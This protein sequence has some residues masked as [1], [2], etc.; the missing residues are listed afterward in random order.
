MHY[1][2]LIQ[3][4]RNQDEDDQ[5]EENPA[6]HP[7]GCAVEIRVLELIQLLN[8]TPDNKI[9]QKCIKCLMYITFNIDN[10]NSI[11]REGI[12]P[13]LVKWA[14]H[15]LE[16]NRM[17]DTRTNDSTEIIPIDKMTR[18]IVRI[19]RTL[20]ESEDNVPVN[21]TVFDFLLTL[22]QILSEFSYCDVLEEGCAAIA[23]LDFDKVR[24]YL[25]AVSEARICRCVVK[26][27]IHPERN[28]AERALT[29]IINISDGTMA[30]KERILKCGLLPKLL[31]LLSG[32]CTGDILKNVCTLIRNLSKSPAHIQQI[33]DAQLIP[34]L[35]KAAK[36][37]RAEVRLEA[38][39]AIRTMIKPGRGTTEQVEYLV[40]QGVLEALCHLLT[41]STDENTLAKKLGGLA[42]ILERVKDQTDKLSSFKKRI[43]K[44][45]GRK[46]N[47]ELNNHI[48]CAEEN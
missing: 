28:V 12:I 21:L 23:N 33:I 14:E 20:T 32:S 29:A 15:C 46:L 34:G 16:I 18:R 31:Q 25:G 22:S 41:F 24:I 8:T 44:C 1:S 45:G 3:G 43:E 9:A 38:T 19:Y 10:K 13:P 30:C 40:A 39:K 47:K 42:F 36:T 37:G 7:T 6:T 2:F 5:E 17:D 35:I 4:K 27:L 26:L 11:V 48:A